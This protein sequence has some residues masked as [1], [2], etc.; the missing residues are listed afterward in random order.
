MKAQELLERIKNLPDGE[1][2]FYKEKDGTCVVTNEW[3]I[4]NFAGDGFEGETFEEAAEKMIAYFDRHI[5][6]R[7]ES[8]V[9]RIVAES[10]WPSLSSV[11][12]YVEN[13]REKIHFELSKRDLVHALDK[14]AEHIAI[15]GYPANSK[16]I[17]D[18]NGEWNFDTALPHKADAEEIKKAFYLAE[19]TIARAKGE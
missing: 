8:M 16:G 4:G 12:E 11:F 1:E 9:G 17:Y 5:G 7:H 18:K 14:I 13:E 10:G 19:K 2:F 6:H 3:L 15:V